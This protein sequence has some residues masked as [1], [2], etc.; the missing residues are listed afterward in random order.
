[1]E[2]VPMN[3]ARSELGMKSVPDR[4]IKHDFPFINICK[5]AREMLKTEGDPEV[6]NLPEGPCKC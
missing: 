4:G 5:V 2:M 1:M 6:F 3:V